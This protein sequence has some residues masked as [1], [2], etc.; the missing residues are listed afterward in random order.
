MSLK[1]TI[2]WLHLWLGLISGTIVFIICL[3]GCLWVFNDE[4]RALLNPTPEVKTENK[5][6]LSPSALITSVEKNTYPNKVSSFSIKNDN[7]AKLGMWND[8]TNKEFIVN[9]YTG[10]VLTTLEYGGGFNFFNFVLDGHRHLWLPWNI[11]RPIINYSTLVFVIMLISGLVLWWPK[12]KSAAQQRFKFKW[13]D[14]TQWKRKNY[15]LHNVLGFYSMI[16]LLIIALTGMTWGL[17]WY[18]DSVYWAV[19]GGKQ[20][21]E[22]QKHFS[23]TL[24]IANSSLTSAAIVDKISA[25]IA[26]KAD[27]DIDHFV[28]YFPNSKDKASSFSVYAYPAMWDFKYK[29]FFFDQYTAKQIPNK[30]ASYANGNAADKLQHMYYGLHVGEIL[31]FPGKV[32]AFLASLVGASLPVTGVYI[33]WGRRKKEKKTTKSKKGSDTIS[34]AKPAIKMVKK[35]TEINHS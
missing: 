10:K 28:I 27:P 12:N 26:A 7:T 29:A 18:K 20:R 9:A 33:W 35:K 30:M 13:K 4:I 32:L 22:W 1:K 21:P 34:K 6:Y 24:Q 2:G 31:G 23:D 17:S 5:S 3:T 11:G 16:L 14:T 8:S 19:S 25:E 15:D